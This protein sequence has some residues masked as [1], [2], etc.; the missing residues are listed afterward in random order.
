MKFCKKC[1]A[2]TDRNSEN[3]CKVCL[4]LK[5]KI[6]YQ[7]DP[8]K[9]KLRSQEWRSKNPEKVTESCKRYRQENE[10]K[11]KSYNSL[12]YANNTDRHRLMS[13]LWKYKNYQKV[14]TIRHNYRA[15]KRGAIGSLSVDLK[16]KLFSLQRGKCACCG[17]NLG[18]DFHMDH[19]MP[20]YLGGANEDWNIQLLRS[21]CNLQKNAKHP[22]DFMQSRGFLL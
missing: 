16:D 22:I 9:A 18:N 19:I 21:K 13:D 20:L 17:E 2:N 1:N 15:R 12:W 4:K 11:V 3:R 5:A 6:S 14:K 7:K 8:E 10:V